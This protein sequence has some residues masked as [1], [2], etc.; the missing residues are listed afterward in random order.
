MTKKQEEWRKRKLL[1]SLRGG[2]GNKEL[3]KEV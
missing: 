3:A 1:M 2:S